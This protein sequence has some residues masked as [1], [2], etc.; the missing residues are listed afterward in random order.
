MFTNNEY[1][2][3]H[4]V[5]GEC[6]NNAAAAATKVYCNRYALG[7][8]LNSNVLRRLARRN[9]KRSANRHRGRPRTTRTP[10]MEEV[11]VNLVY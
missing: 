2:D 1:E 5:L 3:M 8:H 4:L 7:R 10:Q 6:R 11:V 9:G